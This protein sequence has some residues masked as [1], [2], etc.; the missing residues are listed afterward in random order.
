[1]PG[2]M[3]VIPD[4]H[5]SP[6]HI[7]HLMTRPRQGFTLLELLLVIAV[8]VS[9]LGVATPAIQG[10]MS[11]SRLKESADTVYN[12]LFEAQQLAITLGTETEFRLYQAP[13]LVTPDPIPPLRKVQV[14]VLRPA[15]DGADATDATQAF[16]PASSADALHPSVVVS[17]Q[18]V[19]T[20][21]LTLGFT[22]ETKG[23]PP[24]GYLAFRFH[25][26]GT[27]NLPQGQ[28]WFLTLLERHVEEGK[29]KPKNFITLQIDPATGTLRR[30]QP[31]A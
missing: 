20:S 2:G 21:L 30:F 11:A 14:F 15:P 10:A 1:M 6:M 31:G 24:A 12:R 25:A 13:D 22:N 23:A 16:S 19:Y 27:T 26:D 28:T 4:T 9:L 8:I 5:H 3:P 17:S 7:R 18:P 29:A